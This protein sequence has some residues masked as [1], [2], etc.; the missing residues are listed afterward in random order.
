MMVRI[1]LLICLISAAR[2]TYG[3]FIYLADTKAAAG[4]T[5]PGTFTQ[6]IDLDGHD[7]E[8]EY[9]GVLRGSSD[10][11]IMHEGGDTDEQ[12]ILLHFHDVTIPQ[13]AT[14]TSAKIQFQKDS[15]GET[16]PCD[17][18]F[19]AE[20][21]DNATDPSSGLADNW[22][23]N[24]TVTTAEVNWSLPSWSGDTVGDQGANQ[25]SVDFA[26]VIQEIVD[27]GGW[28]SG[29]DINILMKTGTNK[30]EAEAE[31]HDGDPTGAPEIT[32]EYTY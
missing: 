11:E 10:L 19:Y 24:A 26:S 7:W 3:Q 15:D 28:T 31:A 9:D 27:R 22:I 18:I 8:Q 14:I 5:T 20:D 4:G 23:D 17:A 16:R 29:N 21:V 13:G 32:I 12:K 25:L 1:I 2:P 30:G 6:R